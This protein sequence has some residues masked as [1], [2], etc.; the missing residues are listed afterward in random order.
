MEDFLKIKFNVDNVVDLKK[1]GVGYINDG[2]SYQVGNQPMYVK[3]NKNIETPL[4]FAGEMESLKAIQRTNTVHV[5]T[6]YMVCKN[7]LIDG[8]GYILIMDYMEMTSLSTWQS[9]FGEKLAKMHQFNINLISK[10]KKNENSVGYTGDSSAVYHFGFDVP[11]CCGL[12]PQDNTWTDDWVEFY[13]RQRLE[14]TINMIAKKSSDRELIELW[15][16]LQL[17]FH[18]LFGTITMQPSLLHGD[19]WAGNVGELV[20]QP[21]MFDPASFYGHHEL[22]L[23][24]SSMFGGF[25]PTFFKSYHSLIP[26]DDGFAKRQDLY[27]LFHYLNHWNHFG[28][29]YRSQTIST[30]QKVLK[31]IN[32]LK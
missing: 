14:N 19:L 21:V 4:M 30:M 26:K 23:S 2:Q 12:I 22:E 3:M 16:E 27:K 11:T 31:N 10:V 24:I 28:T 7:P 20:D 1:K 18:K 25:E 6:P 32:T 8:N 9:K 5:P 29:S 13:G 17:N 15:S